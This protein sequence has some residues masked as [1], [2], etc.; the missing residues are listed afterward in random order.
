MDIALQAD[1]RP[2]GTS[3]PY[4]DEKRGPVK[5]ED[6]LKENR[7]L[8]R[9]IAGLKAKK[10]RKGPA[11]N[12]FD[13][14]AVLQSVLDNTLSSIHIKDTEGR[15]L[16]VNRWFEEHTKFTREKLIGRTPYDIYPKEIVDAFLSADRRVMRTK[17]PFEVE[18]D[19]PL[20]DGLHTFISAKYPVLDSKGS[21]RA[22]LGIATDITERKRTEEALKRS[23]ASLR[24]AQRIARFGNWEWN[25]PKDEIYRSD[26]I[27]RMLGVKKGAMKAGFGAFLDIVHPDDRERV[28]KA[29]DAALKGGEPFSVDYRVATRDGA[30]RLIHSEGQ[31]IFDAAG[32]R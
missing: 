31:A 22:I 16:M 4:P 9:E 28:R 23:E 14:I 18:E 20:A 30:R 32:S 10:D 5:K 24:N 27:Y 1:F 17:K 21:V 19:V 15:F 13:P 6:L 12:G 3:A 25:V 29:V 7:A 2:G 11:G 8:R 26:E